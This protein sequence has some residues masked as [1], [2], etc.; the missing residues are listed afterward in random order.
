LAIENFLT[1]NEGRELLGYPELT[2]PLPTAEPAP[3][4]PATGLVNRFRNLFKR[5]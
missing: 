1:T 5:K 3:E 4:Q 2:E